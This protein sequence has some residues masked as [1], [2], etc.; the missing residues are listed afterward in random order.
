MKNRSLVRKIVYIVLIALL[1]GP[2]WYVASPATADRVDQNRRVIE[3]GAA[4]G[5]LAQ[6]RE[7]LGLAQSTI[8]EIDP[9][10]ETIKLATFGMKGI[11]ANILW[12]QANEY[13]KKEDWTSYSAVLEQISKVEPN[14]VSVWIFQAWNVSYNIAVEFY[15]YR[16]RYHY[17]KEGIYFMR[18]GMRYNANDT[19]LLT[20]V[21]DFTGQKLGRADERIQYRRLFRDDDD[22]HD[23]LPRILRDPNGSRD[24]WL[25]GKQPYKVAWDMLDEGKPLRGMNHIVFYSR[26]G[27][28]NIYYGRA[29]ADDGRFGEEYRTAWNWASQEWELFGQADIPTSAAFVIHLADLENKIIERERL[30]KELTDL[31]PELRDKLVEAKKAKLTEGDRR[32]LDTPESKLD[33]AA[34]GRQFDLRFNIQ[35]SNEEVAAALPEDKRPQGTEIA[36]ALTQAQSQVD[37]I[38]RYRGIVNFMDWKNVCSVEQTDVC[39]EARQSIF[40]A[41]KALAIPDFLKAQA[42]Y[43]KG[44]AAWGKVIQDNP[45]FITDSLTSPDLVELIAEYERFLGQ[46]N[47]TL[48]AD[49]PLQ[50]IIDKHRDAME[51][52]RQGM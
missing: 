15:D 14:F 6:Q 24:N 33:Q 2:L 4:G 31:E 52:A 47:E 21:G 40:N 38:D 13:Q 32:L 34:I 48:P 30:T 19:R 51:Q 7:N 11:A 28:C 45:S 37:M 41:R 23:G 43:N 29:L 10:S 44:V 27:L 17:I 42:E 22:Y 26:P 25:V 5:L 18:D 3:P 20:G 8:G 35:V 49:F 46:V 16:D 12:I 36:A 9:V 39:R 1:L 50:P